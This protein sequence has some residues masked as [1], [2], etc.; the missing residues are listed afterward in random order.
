MTEEEVYKALDDAWID[1]EFIADHENGM[2]IIIKY[3]EEDKDE[4]KEK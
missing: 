4:E 3:E 1:Y 2:H